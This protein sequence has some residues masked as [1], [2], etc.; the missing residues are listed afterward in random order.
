VTSSA[1]ADKKTDLKRKWE[2]PIEPPELLHCP[3]RK[4]NSAKPIYRYIARADD[5][6]PPE[7]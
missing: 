2:I 3:S 6:L 7:I 5:G 4:G 1:I